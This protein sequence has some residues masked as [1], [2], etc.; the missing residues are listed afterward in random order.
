MVPKF[1]S[2]AHFI[3]FKNMY[4]RGAPKIHLNFHLNSHLSSHLRSHLRRDLNFHLNFQ[5]HEQ[6]SSHVFETE[7]QIET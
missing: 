6:L 5:K 1:R 3:K 4:L 7:H 2:L